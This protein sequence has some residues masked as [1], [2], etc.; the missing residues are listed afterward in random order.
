MS[1][2]RLVLT[3]DDFNEP[4]GAPQ[5]QPLPPAV[6]GPVAPGL[7]PVDAAPAAQVNIHKGNT[8]A[9]GVLFNPKIAPILAA[10]LGM[11]VGW[12]LTEI[13]GI[14]GRGDSQSSVDL[15]TAV[16]IGA[17]GVSFGVAVLCWD[18][19]V[20]AD[21]EGVRAGAAKS[22]VPLAIAGLVAGYLTS[23]LY[24]S[25]LGNSDTMPSSGTLYL[26]R[27]IGWGGFGAILGVAIGATSR[28]QKL[29]INGGF[30]G[31]IGGVVGGIMFEWMV[32]DANVNVVIGRLI[33]LAI[34][35][36][37]IAAATRAVET[38]RKTAW[39]HVVQGG[40]TGKE[41]ILYHATTRIGAAPDCEIFIVKDPSVTKYN[42]VITDDGISRV[43]SSSADGVVLVNQQRVS[44]P[45]RLGSGD[46][47][48]VG[49][50][51]LQYAER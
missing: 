12:A 36:V 34:I 30:G 5:G 32:D 10:V 11:A 51:I 35:G 31:A 44:S 43:L 26:A 21:W 28:S 9:Q 22:V 45:C 38:A 50:T 19:I 27:A 8:P 16:W 33:G 17:I 13:F 3:E 23:K 49:N 24:G 18:S 47:I 40:M 29:A 46:R 6:G 20:T 42:A 37:L 14:V 7:P 25:L 39:L 1:D 2:D 4:V 48:H 41:F 15:W